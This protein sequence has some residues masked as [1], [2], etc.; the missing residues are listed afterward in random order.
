MSN[1]RLLH[2]AF[3]AALTLGP[4]ATTPQRDR[5][6]TEICRVMSLCQSELDQIHTLSMEA[7]RRFSQIPLVDMIYLDTLVRKQ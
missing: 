4:N 7:M 2:Q 6:N 1:L 5:A 3:D